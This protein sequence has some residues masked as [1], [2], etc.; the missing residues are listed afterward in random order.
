MHEAREVALYMSSLHLLLLWHTP[1]GVVCSVPGPC[2]A[3][4]LWTA[5]TPYPES[6]ATPA[7]HHGAG[8]VQ[9]VGRELDRHHCLPCCASL[10]GTGLIRPNPCSNAVIPY[11][12][13]PIWT[14]TK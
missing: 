6:R 11:S 14:P 1:A 9:V 12:S 13:S 4:R 8:S 2:L 10:D 5:D 7:G 3:F